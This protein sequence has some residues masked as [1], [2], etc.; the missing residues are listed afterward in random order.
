MRRAAPERPAS[1]QGRPI[2]AAVVKSAAE[3]VAASCATAAESLLACAGVRG[4]G[5]CVAAVD[6]GQIDRR[7]RCRRRRCGSCSCTATSKIAAPGP[8]ALGRGQGC[9]HGR[10]CSKEIDRLVG[11]VCAP[12]RAIP[13]PARSCSWPAAA[14]ATPCTRQGGNVGPDLTPFKRDDV[15]PSA[16]AHRQSQR[17]N[18]RR[19]R[20]LRS[21]PPTSGRTLT[22]I[23]VE[24]DAGVVVLRTAD[25]Q[26]VI[27]PRSDI[28]E[29][30]V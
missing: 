10:R 21:S 1:V 20:E 17:R 15:R 30:S 3:D 8:Q 9:N 14:P 16:L 4:A 28:E 6:A 25:G 26:R 11:V 7:N 24:K 22:G 18:P 19:L 12:A 5:N 2:G 29:M 13:T 27:L 23:V